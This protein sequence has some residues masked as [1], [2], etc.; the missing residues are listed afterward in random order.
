MFSYD[1]PMLD[2]SVYTVKKLLAKGESNTKTLKSDKA[3]KGFITKSL[4]LAPAKSSGFNLCASASAACISGCLHTSGLANIFPRTIIPARIAKARFLRLNPS[5]F[6][7]QLEKELLD[8]YRTASRN[9]LR[10]AVRLNVVSDV[11]WE[12]EIPGLFE[13]FPNVQFYDYT[14]HYKRMQRYLD[15]TLPINL[16][17]TFSWSGR[18]EAEC[19]DVLNKG[20]NVAV[21]FHVKYHGENR[22]PLPV[23]FK[24]FP[25]IDGDITDLRFLDKQGGQVVGLRVK[26]RAKKD[27]ESGFVVAVENGN[28]VA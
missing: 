23:E 19:L 27:F 11:I 16:Q 3:G 18:N 17:L 14:K 20:G 9:G 21:P 26:G 8:S 2:G 10:L 5:E 25:V 24:G 1:V 22:K 12:R 28:V 6:R 4:S 7:K 13:T 15:W